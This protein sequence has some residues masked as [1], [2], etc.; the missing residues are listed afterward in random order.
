MINQAKTG[1]FVMLLCLLCR[2]L[3]L[4]FHALFEHVLPYRRT[5]QWFLHEVF[6]IQEIMLYLQQKYV[7]RTSLYTVRR[8]IRSMRNHVECISSTRDREM[9]LVRPNQHSSSL[10]STRLHILCFVPAMFMS[11]TC[12]HK[13]NPCLR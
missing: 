7:T 4:S 2:Q 5:M 3:A 8:V 6:H 10:S 9:V 12:A 13:N 1:N 11:S